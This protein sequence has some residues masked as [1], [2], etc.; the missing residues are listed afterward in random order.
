MMDMH[1]FAPAAMA[2]R[3]QALVRRGLLR[4]GPRCGGDA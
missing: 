1:A 2:A 4:H 3:A